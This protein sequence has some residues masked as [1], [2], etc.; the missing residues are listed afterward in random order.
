MN[1][2]I[3]GYLGCIKLHK[4]KFIILLLALFTISANNLSAQSTGKIHGVIV[5]SETGEKLIGVNVVLKGTSIGASSGIEG[6]YMITAIPAG[7]Y[8]IVYSM[9]GYAKNTITAVEIKPNQTLKL[10]VTLISE[11]YETEEVVIT[12]KAALNSDAGLLIN[13]QKS[14]SV[15][16]A[17]SSEQISRTGASD[18]ADAVK[19]IVGATIVGGKYVYVRGLGE[20]YSSTQL[21]GAEL[22]SS[23]PNKKSFQLDLLPSNLLDNIVTLKT[24]TPD[25]PGNFSGGIVDVGTKSLPE[26]F[27]FKISGSSS[28]NSQTSFNDNFL[29]YTGTDGNFFGFDDG[30]RSIP[31]ALS[32]P[33]T[34]I[35][36]EVQ[37][38][39]DTEKAQKLDEYSKSFNNVMDFV[40]TS[41]PID[42]SYSIST[43]DRLYLGETSSLGYFG[44]LVYSN[45]SS[46]YENGKVQRYILSDVNSDELNPQ[47]LLNDNRASTESNIGGLF[48]TTFNINPYHQIGGNILYSKIGISETRFQEGSWPQE[49]G[50]SEDAPA[51]YNRVLA[52]TERDILSYQLRGEHNLKSFLN[53]M[54]DWNVSISKTKQDE[55]DR[56]LIST[57]TEFSENGTN[58]IITGSGFDDPSR[59]FRNLED[60][61]NTYNLNIAIPF[62]QWGG[63]IAKIKFG[64]TYQDI[65]RE[66]RERIFSYTVKNQLFNQLDGNLI[67]LFDPANNGITKV[68]TLSGNRLRYSFGNTIR[69]NSKLRNN[70]DGEQNVA[71]FYGM[72]EL[73][74]TRE[75]KLIGG[76]RYES[77]EMNLVSKDTLIQRTNMIENDL[78]PSLNLIY[79]VNDNMNVRVAA[80]QTLARPTFRELAPYSTKEFVNDVE[81]QGN[82]LLKRTLIENYD[83]RWEW[84]TRPGEIIAVSGFY[85]KLK[86]PIELAFAEGSTRS[87]PIV[88][89]VNVENATIMG[90]ELET[91]FRLD[92]LHDTFSNFFISTNLTFIDSDV[93]IAGSELDQRLGIDSTTSRTRELQGQSPVVFNFDIAYINAE[94]GTSASLNLN[95]FGERLS[96]VSA[97]VTPDVFEQ[98]EA[99]LDFIFSQ[100]II[101]VLNLKFSIKNILNSSYKEIYRYKGNDYIYQEY[102]RGLTYTVGLS[103]EI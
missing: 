73:P 11:S 84:F 15:S 18:A 1:C 4:L 62:E 69:D 40:K 67:E 97:N 10:D 41:A 50:L 99:R 55:P 58:Y 83:L 7:T 46:L 48:T 26:K 25:K 94:T 63:H 35:P 30:F 38:R 80:T 87:N 27:T 78:L 24:F 42:Q 2:F 13:R 95:T 22:P 34:E 91:R 16:D 93:D 102:K 86:N 53:T 19:K 43:G 39:F 36:L 61:T 79:Q 66:F 3:N 9:I 17:I 64:V 54:I 76:V 5:D 12:A 60:K 52:Y 47:L 98:P 49:F 70:Y 51:Y 81:L 65:T 100:K 74:L 68:D 8:D 23:D 28:Y 33:N 6:D 57:S 96:R 89:Y 29:S 75:L 88:N 44:S 21:N 72:I 45:S 77:T 103:Y 71:A 90:V 56:R 92:W 59:Y 32:N 20:R 82:P 85:K 101:D 37:A 31:D 14:L